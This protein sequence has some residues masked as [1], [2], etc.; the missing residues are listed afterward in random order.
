MGVKGSQGKAQIILEGEKKDLIDHLELSID[1]FPFNFMV[2]ANHVIV[3]REL[4][5]DG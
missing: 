2:L 5:D 3:S 4:E 1:L